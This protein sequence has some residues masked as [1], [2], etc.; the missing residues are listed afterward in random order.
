MAGSTHAA[1]FRT[2]TSWASTAAPR[3]RS[4]AARA[5]ASG[6]PRARTTSTAWPASPPTRLGHAHPKLV[7]ALK[8]QGEKL[9]HV[10]NIYRIPEQEALADAAVRG[11][12]RRRGVLHQLRHRGDRVRAEDRAQA[13]TGPTASPSGSTSSA[14]RA[15]STAAATRRSTPS[16]NAGYLEGFGPRLPGY[17]HAA[18]RRHGGA[19]GGRRPDH[20][21]HHHRARAG[22]G[23]RAR[24]DR[25]RADRACARS[26]TSTARC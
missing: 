24:A 20:R 3:W 2:T 9:W 5:C 14:S 23:R 6:R 13:T 16:G 15:R 18:V 17:V 11:D 12:L 22:R 7:E 26:A 8:D 25:R 10:S 1:P 19:E 4:S 21:G